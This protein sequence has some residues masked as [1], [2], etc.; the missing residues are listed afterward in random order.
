MSIDSMHEVAPP[1][2]PPPYPSHP[3]IIS[4]FDLPALPPITPP[5]LPPLPPPPLTPFGSLHSTWGPAPAPPLNTVATDCIVCAP[6]CVCTAL[7]VDRQTSPCSSSLRSTDSSLP[8]TPGYITPAVWGVPLT[9][10]SPP[11]TLPPNP[12]PYLPP[13]P[14]TPKAMGGDFV[15]HMVNL[16]RHMVNLRDLQQFYHPPPNLNHQ[17]HQC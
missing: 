7:C 16:V 12:P 11:L 5:T 14:L 4:P 6:P 9:P 8:S 15:R 2:P 1:L 17:I 3:P 13:P 10:L